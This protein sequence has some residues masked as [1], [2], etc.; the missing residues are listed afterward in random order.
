MNKQRA[1]LL[2]SLITVFALLFYLSP[3]FLTPAFPGLQLR[4]ARSGHH[5]SVKTVQG[6]KKGTCCTDRCFVDKS[7]VHHC[8]PVAGDSCECGLSANDTDPEGT[9]DPALAIVCRSDSLLPV[10][11][12]SPGFSEFPGIAADPDLSA[13]TPPPRVPLS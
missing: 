6:C 3:S 1:G 2:T 4:D 11:L 8:V 12:S 7:G 5:H 13:P 9:L 10:M